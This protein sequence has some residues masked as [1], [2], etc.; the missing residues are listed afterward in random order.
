MDNLE[1]FLCNTI[2]N[3]A[4]VVLGS[5]SVTAMKNQPDTL[6]QRLDETHS[7]LSAV[8]MFKRLNRNTAFKLNA[9]DP[10]KGLHKEVMEHFANVYAP[11]AIDTPV[12]NG[13]D[14][15]EGFFDSRMKLTQDTTERFGVGSRTWLH[16]VHWKNV[17]EFFWKYNVAK[18]CGLDGIH[19]RII[20]ALMSDPT[21]S[22]PQLLEMHLSLLFQL[23][24]LTGITPLRW[25]KGL[26]FAL[27]KSP[28]AQYISDCRPVA[29][30][31]MFRRAFEALVYKAIWD[32]GECERMRQF[33]PTQ[34]GF[35]KGHS[36]LLQAALSSDM[37]YM[38]HK[39]L[40]CFIDFKQ[41]YDKV[42]LE[43]L[44]RKLVN[45]GTPPVLV[46]LIISLFSRCSHQILVNGS[47]TEEVPVFSGLFQGSLLSPLLFLRYIDDLA[48]RLAEGSTPAVPNSLLFADDL[49]LLTPTALVLQAQCDIVTKWA[50]DNCMVVGIRKCGIIGNCG[51][52]IILQGQVVPLVK[53]YKYLGLPHSSTDIQLTAHV[54]ACAEKAARTLAACKRNS[55]NWPEWLKLTLFKTFVRPQLEY[56]GQLMGNHLNLLGPL[57][58]VQTEAVKWI[59]PYSPQ[60]V[61]S[62]GVL[63][64]PNMETRIMGLAALFSEH[65]QNMALDHPA[66]RF[67]TEILGPGPWSPGVIIPR[68]VANQLYA[69]LLATKGPDMTIRKAMKRWT[70]Q[71]IEQKSAV[72]RYISRGS[73]RNYYGPDKTLY[74]K[75]KTLR[76]RALTW[77]VGSFACH[78]PCPEGHMFTRACVKRCIYTHWEPELPL[79]KKPPDPP[80]PYCFIDDFINLQLE[81][82]TGDA[83]QDLLD[84]IDML[85]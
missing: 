60:L 21:E 77:R 80:R 28:E 38:A 7:H 59:L 67:S 45:T 11:P 69:N 1:D 68:A 29:L 71:Q 73:R 57:E 6:L 23:S 56:G 3:T 64:L 44:I 8:R 66:R 19:T 81:Q 70:L 49:Q 40:R 39:P 65:C 16:Y 2:R 83:L 30:T 14:L 72:A 43:L 4:E 61:S 35:R 76:Q 26:V 32:D 78:Q 36:T 27:P 47:P 13:R 17:K 79:R 62:M 25:N 74:W 58:S 5:Y 75:D 10:S 42:P 55:S 52:D 18:S 37:T 84:L 41:A 63:A 82:E 20:R 12:Y 31:A 34:A 33:H 15:L 53:S 48:E 24:M 9:A 50:D 51:M 46:S 85:K 22:E 54:Q